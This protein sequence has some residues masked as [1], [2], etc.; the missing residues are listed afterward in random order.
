MGSRS[1]RCVR[2]PLVPR[3][4]DD[5]HRLTHRDKLTDPRVYLRCEVL[6]VVADLAARH[7]T[8]IPHVQEPGDVLECKAESHGVANEPNPG[9]RAVGILAVAARVRGGAGNSPSRS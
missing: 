3:L 6:R 5:V 2:Q 4:K 9:H 1:G 8:R 7:A